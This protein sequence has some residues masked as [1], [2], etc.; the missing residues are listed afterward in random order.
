MQVLLAPNAVFILFGY[1]VWIYCLD[2]LSEV[3]TFLTV[4]ASVV[5]P[6][7]YCTNLDVIFDY[8]NKSMT[9]S[10]VSSTG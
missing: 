9:G 1:T 10:N 7:I 2:I 3:F 6:G 5:Q 8:E 4:D